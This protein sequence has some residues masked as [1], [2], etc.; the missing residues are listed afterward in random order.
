MVKT[1]IKYKLLNW[2]FKD[3][4]VQ[5]VIED[6]G[7]PYAEG[8][9]YWWK[10]KKVS[11]KRFMTNQEKANK[12]MHKTY[13]T[14]TAKEKKLES[15]TLAAPKARIGQQAED[16]FAELAKKF[17]LK[18]LSSEAKMSAKLNYAK[19]KRLT[20]KGSEI[21]AQ[22]GIG[23]GVSSLSES[24][25]KSS[26]S[27]SELNALIATADSFEDGAEFVR[28]LNKMKNREDARDTPMPRWSVINGETYKFSPEVTSEIPPGFYFAFSSPE[29]NFLRKMDISVDESYVL[30]GSQNERILADVD[31]FMSKAEV[32]KTNGF[33]HKRGYLLHGPPGGGK[34]SM[35]FQIAESIIKRGGIVIN[36][37][38]GDFSAA[39]IMIQN[40]RKIEP[41]KPICVMIEDIDALIHERE[42]KE[43]ELLNMLDGSLQIDA[44]VFVA[45]TNYPERLPPRLVNR[46]RRFDKIIEFG[47]PDAAVRRQYFEK[48]LAGS[49]QEEIEK[50]VTA[51]AGMGYA[52]LAEMIISTKCIGTTI[53]ESAEGLKEISKLR[54]SSEKY[55]SNGRKMGFN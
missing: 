43:V 23:R 48:K 29:G 4:V 1:K 19:R 36:L 41:G 40:L 15:L 38:A 6:A 46:P 30:S 17:P 5:P 26:V 10:G 55:E 13:S 24:A 54:I 9:S 27:Q 47:Y 53:E 21:L 20:R 49:T 28:M 16:K 22:L 12:A 31:I 2:D 45:T 44:V 42:G 3:Q 11:K 39:N 33:A 14:E 7:V 51:T 37:I 35:S 34:T 25:T 50:Y 52:S 18:P 32:Y 8:D